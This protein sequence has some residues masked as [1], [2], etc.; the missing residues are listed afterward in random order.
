MSETQKI[1]QD[2]YLQA[3]SDYKIVSLIEKCTGKKHSQF[4]VRN[5]RLGETKS[6]TVEFQ[7][8]VKK[9]QTYLLEMAKHEKV[10]L[11]SLKRSK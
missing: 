6:E 9:V 5:H 3:G 1:L 4:S 10:V 11:K 8:S 2:I 7:K